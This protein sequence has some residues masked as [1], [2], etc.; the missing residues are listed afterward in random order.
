MDSFCPEEMEHIAWDRVEIPRRE[1]EKQEKERQEEHFL[2]LGLYFVEKDFHFGSN[3]FF[4]GFRPE[5]S[6]GLLKE[7]DREVRQ[8]SI[9]KE[10]MLEEPADRWAREDVKKDSPSP[11]S[12]NGVFHSHGAFAHQ[13]VLSGRKQ[14]QQHQEVRQ[15][16]SSGAT[17]AM[18]EGSGRAK[19]T[20]G[21]F[22]LLFRRQG[23]RPFALVL[24]SPF[25]TM[26]VHMEFLKLKEWDPSLDKVAFMEATKKVKGE[27]VITLYLQQF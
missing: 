25:R 23:R 20:T 2:R 4:V 9:K 21:E 5:L 10:R 6:E 14:Q 11:D 12:I 22:V 8:S 24:Q 1:L 26:Q 19:T 16:H 15:L 27:N 18:S 13:R 7:I 17:M 3:C